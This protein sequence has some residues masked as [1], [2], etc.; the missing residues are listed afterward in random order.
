MFSRFRILLC[1]PLEMLLCERPSASAV[2]E[3]PRPAVLVPRTHADYHHMVTRITLPPCPG[4]APFELSNGAHWAGANSSVVSSDVCGERTVEPVLPVRVAGKCAHRH[5]KQQRAVWAWRWCHRRR[6][7][8]SAIKAML[9]LRSDVWGRDII[10]HPCPTSVCVYTRRWLTSRRTPGWRLWFLARYVNQGDS[11]YYGYYCLIIAQ[12][13]VWCATSRRNTAET[14]E[15]RWI[16][17]FMAAR[18]GVWL[19]IYFRF[20]WSRADVGHPWLLVLPRF[21][22]RAA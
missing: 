10:C 22:V 3:V 8:L 1:E 14:A 9:S 21:S 5:G 12:I 13:W 19:C 6:P 18:V 15:S 11:R 2:A 20:I 4:D 7:P 17:W 16:L